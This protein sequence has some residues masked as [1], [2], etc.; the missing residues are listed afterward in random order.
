ME[1]QDRE[2]VTKSVTKACEH[3]V[4]AEA[5]STHA[6]VARKQSDLVAVVR[7]NVGTVPSGLPPRRSGAV[8]REETGSVSINF[9]DQPTK[10]MVLCLLQLVLHCGSVHVHVMVHHPEMHVSLH[11][12]RLETRAHTKFSV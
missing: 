12:T 4:Q 2:I 9:T 11:T 6:P 1:F 8:N 5:H 10:V 7:K 3:E